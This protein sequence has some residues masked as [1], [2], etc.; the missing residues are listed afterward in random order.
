M[1]MTSETAVKHAQ[2]CLLGGA[3]GDALGAPVEFISAA[4]IIGVFG[5]QGIRDYHP[6]Y[7]RLGA[8]P[9][10]DPAML[11][12]LKAEVHAW[13]SQQIDNGYTNAHPLSEQQS[14]DQNRRNRYDN[15]ILL[16]NEEHL[17]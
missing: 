7:G 10:I 14:L 4:N 16:P 12:G 1:V 6:A 2:A 17:L 3:V 11:A 8:I 9:V 15:F 13:A 5:D